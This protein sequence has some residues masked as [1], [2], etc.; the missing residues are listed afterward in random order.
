MQV[1][2]C[3]RKKTAC[4]RDNTKAQLKVQVCEVERLRGFLQTRT[5]L[6][7]SDATIWGPI[8]RNVVDFYVTFFSFSSWEGARFLD[9]DGFLTIMV[10]LD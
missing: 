7:A 6:E 4:A 2:V 10:S 3:S 9:V 5:V 8:I 1:S